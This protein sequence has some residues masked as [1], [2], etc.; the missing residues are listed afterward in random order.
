[1]RR[2]IGHAGIVT[3]GLVMDLSRLLSKAQATTLS[4][5]TIRVRTAG[6][7]VG[8]ETHTSARCC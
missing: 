1:M 4:D 3:S 5:F 2:S 8:N 6:Y 7:V